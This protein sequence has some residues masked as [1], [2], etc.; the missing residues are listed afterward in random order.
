MIVLYD[1][2]ARVPPQDLADL[3]GTSGVPGRTGGG[4]GPGR[5]DKRARAPGQR[6]RQL[7][8][9]DAQVVDRDRDRGQAHG[10]EQI[11]G[12][13][14]AGIL[15]DHPVSGSEPGGQDPFDAIERAAGD[16]QAGA[17]DA[18]CG[19]LAGRQASQP[20]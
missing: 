1:P 10:R 12:D 19:Q 16:G 4:L 20:W 14:M 18:V 17:V 13:R 6:G 5:D 8:G 3:G 7:G 2:D 15:D 9:P 11:E